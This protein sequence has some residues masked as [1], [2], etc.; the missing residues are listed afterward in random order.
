[1]D[2]VIIYDGRDWP[3]G[4]SNGIAIDG[5]SSP[6]ESS[7]IFD[8]NMWGSDESSSGSG[9]CSGATAVSSGDGAETGVL[10]LEGPNGIFD[11]VSSN[12]KICFFLPALIS[13][14]EG[15]TDVRER[16]VRDDP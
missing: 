3:C 7:G 2:C 4:R 11:G 6:S 5:S 15:V 12:A 9:S 14:G 10:G 8:S 13:S 1:M 16:A